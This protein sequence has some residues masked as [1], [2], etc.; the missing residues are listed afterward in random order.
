MEKEMDM[1]IQLFLRY[2]IELLK[3]KYNDTLKGPEDETEEDKIFREGKNFA[4]YDALDLFDNLINIRGYDK[5]P[6]GVIVPEL[7]KK[8]DI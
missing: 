6:F 5:K 4:Y 8:A 2:Y 7:G 1:D 3:E